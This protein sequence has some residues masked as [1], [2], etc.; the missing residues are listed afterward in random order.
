MAR[1]S[2]TYFQFKQ[3][4][5]DQ[6]QCAMKVTMDACLFGA[7][8]DVEESQRILDIGTGTGLLSLMAAQRSSAHIDAVELDDDAARQARQN[9]AQ[10]PWSD[11]ITVTQSAIQQ[12]FGAPDGYDTIICNPPFFENSLKAAND[13]RTMARHTES[14]SFSDLVQ[15]TSRLLHKKWYC[16]DNSTGKVVSVFYWCCRGYKQSERVIYNSTAAVPQSSRPPIHHY[17]EQ[18]QVIQKFCPSG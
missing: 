13:K 18:K 3:F 17:A 10:S 4:R 16:M 9:V 12:F 6:D 15:A 14:L 1:K 2:N 5:V 8:V 11:R 7:L